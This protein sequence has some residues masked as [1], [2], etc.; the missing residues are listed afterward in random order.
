MKNT[1]DRFSFILKPSIVNNGGVGVFALHDIAKDIYMELFLEDFQEEIKEKKDVPMDLQGYCLNLPDNRLLCPR[2]FNRMDIGNYLNHS[3]SA[4]V[5]YKKGKGY[6]SIRDI[7]QGEEILANYRDLEEPVETRE[8][9][10]KGV[11][12]K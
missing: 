5:R 4:N 8:E 11:N 10:Y 12:S 1:T 3:E 6:F 7:K 9:Y 2:L